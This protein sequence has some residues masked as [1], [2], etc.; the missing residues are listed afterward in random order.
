VTRGEIALD[1]LADLRRTHAAGDVRADL[2]GREVVLVGWVQRRRDHGGVIFVD[3]RDRENLVQVVFRPDVS[4]EAHER[5]GELRAEY[6]ILVRGAVQPRSPETVNTK[7]LTGEVEVAVAE[8]R[9]LNSA[10]PPPFAVEEEA[11]ADEATRLRHRIH[12]LRRPPLQRALRVRHR[13]YQSV[14]RTL[15]EREFLEIETP[16]LAKSTPEGARDFLVPSRLQQGS[17][18]ALPQSPQ[19]MK[20]LLMIAG[21]DRYFQI[22]RCFRDEDQRADRQLEFTQVDIEM[23]F[24]GVD[25]PRSTSRC[26]SSASTTC[27]RSSKRSRCEAARK[28]RAS[29]CRA[30]FRASLTPRPW[31]ATAAIDPIRESSWS[32]ST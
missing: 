18:Y 21:F 14:R 27:W 32:W 6:V 9:L 5:A 22:V 29:S 12:D 10:T 8:L 30:R 15:S 23:S 24:V 4:P 28:P 1:G 11:D 26:R 17:F 13:L 7:L 2:V 3:L 31:S 25:S 20:Q 19:I 16:M